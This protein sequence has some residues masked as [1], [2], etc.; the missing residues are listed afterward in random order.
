LNS[1]R[2]ILLQAKV[3]FAQQGFDGVSIRSLA[4][5]VNL[6]PAALY[7]HFPD[8]KTL[9]LETVQ[10]AFAEQEH[11]FSKVWCSEGTA[12]QKLIE[13]IECFTE[14]MFADPAFHRLMQRELLIADNERMQLLAEDVFKEQFVELMN[15]I[16]QLAPRLDAHLAAVSV[17]GL[18]CQQLEMQPLLKCL[19]DW[20]LQHEQPQSLAKHINDILLNGI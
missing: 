20:R 2:K 19:P 13:F 9:Y 6:S 14:L 17:L 18:V 3:L 12:R 16:R 8:K 15:I 5:A 4:K 1:K 7:H 10:C 11:V